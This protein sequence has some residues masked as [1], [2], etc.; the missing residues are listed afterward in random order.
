MLYL[1]FAILSGVITAAVMKASETAGRSSVAVALVNYCIAALVMFAAWVAHGGVPLSLITVVCGIY[2]GITWTFGLV[3]SMVAIRLFGVAISAAVGRVGIVL[4]IVLSI[5]IWLEIP[6]VVQVVG[7]ALA[8]VAITF[9]SLRVVLKGRGVRWRD[10][11]VLLGLWVVAGAAQFASK[12]Y[13]QVCPQDEK[14]G[15]LVVLFV[16]ACCISFTWLKL[17]RGAIRRGDIAYGVGVGVPNSIGGFFL[18]SSLHVLPG[19]VVFPTLGAARVLLVALLGVLFWRERLGVKGAIGIA[20]A[21][22]ALILVNL[23]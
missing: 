21:I 19:I 2:G 20:A 4:P 17:L 16:V 5:A 9:L 10:M 22:A 14:S 12:L 1:T 8:V 7:I 23:R 18:V 11:L 3:L 15:Y 6:S 13:A